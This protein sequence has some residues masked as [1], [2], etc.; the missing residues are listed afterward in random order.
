MAGDIAV[1]VGSDG[2]TAALSENGKLQVYRRW[3]GSWS[4]QRSREFQMN[5]D[6]GLKEH[7]R[8]LSHL[9]DFLEDCDVFVG[10]SVTG[11]PFFEL[12]KRGASVWECEGLPQEFLEDIRYQEEERRNQKPGS[13]EPP[14]PVTERSPGVFYVALKEIQEGHSGLTSKQILLP[15]LRQPGVLRLEIHCGHIPPWL[16]AELSGNR[17]TCHQKALGPRDQLLILETPSCREE[18]SL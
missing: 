1:F 18:E 7:R 12:E 13:A 2:Q 17:F 11:V 10:R 3:Q 8:Q 14:H 5:P 4:L 15:L 9:M 6:L 16:E